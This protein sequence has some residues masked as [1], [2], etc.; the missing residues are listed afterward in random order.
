MKEC[1]L[2]YCRILTELRKRV[3]W[4]ARCGNSARRDLWRGYRVTDT[5]TLPCQFAYRLGALIV[6]A[7]W[8]WNIYGHAMFF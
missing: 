5:P 4:G 1:S 2:A 8:E 7:E 6:S 3:L